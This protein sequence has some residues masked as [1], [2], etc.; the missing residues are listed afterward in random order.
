MEGAC[1]LLQ[2]AVLVRL[3]RTGEAR[4]TMAHLARIDPRFS[5]AAE[6]ML[7]RFGDSPLMERFLAELV[8]AGAP[9]GAGQARSVAAAPAAG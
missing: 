8:L 4:T 9:A 7:R 1:L 3:D 2:T 6:R 5:L